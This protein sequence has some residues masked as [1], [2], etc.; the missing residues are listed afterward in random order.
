MNRRGSFRRASVSALLAALTV[1]S[2]TVAPLLERGT[3]EPETGIESE[4]D[5]SRCAH[6][7]DHRLCTQ[8]GAN[9]SIVAPPV[10]HRPLHGLL[11]AAAATAVARAHTPSPREGHAPRAPP[12]A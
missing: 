12:L 2:G 6:A 11:R 10:D 4:H 3:L 8:M 5:L 1:A 9:R 7:H